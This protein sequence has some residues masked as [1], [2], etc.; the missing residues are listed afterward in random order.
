MSTH[1]FRL[2]NYPLRLYSGKDALENLPAE[3]KRQRA[4]RAFIVC[5]RTVSR[6]TPLIERI[7][8][9]LGDTFAG[10]FDKME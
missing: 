7:R 6:K 8:N 3:L 1:D 2:V 9:I 5:G 4:S 10:V